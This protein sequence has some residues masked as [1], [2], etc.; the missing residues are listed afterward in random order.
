[1]PDAPQPR[2]PPLDGTVL[3]AHLT[4]GVRNVVLVVADGLGHHQLM[5]EIAAGNAPKLA[6]II[7]ASNAS[8][9]PL[10]SVFPTTTVAALGALNSAVTPAEHGLLSYTVFVPEFETIVEMIR[11]GPQNRRISFT[12]PEFGRSPEDF[13]WAETMYHRLH[14][15]GLERTFAVNPRGFAGTALTRMLHRGATYEGY[16]A[17]SSLSA[18]VAKALEDRPHTPTYVYAYWP[19]VDTISH[20]IGPRTEEHAAEVTAFDAA[21]ARLLRRIDGDATL[22]LL[23]ADHGHVDTGPEQQIA[24]DEHPELLGMLRQPPAGERRAIYLY[25]TDGRTQDVLSYVRANLRHV[26]T[27]LTQDE[28]IECGLF[29]PGP[30]SERA[31]GRIGDVILFP[32]GNLQ[33]VADIRG[34]DGTLMQQPQFKGLH[35]GLTEDEALVPLLAVRP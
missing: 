12:D 33:L 26:S 21:F 27:M 29:G 2:L 7:H 19:T 23:T 4:K 13:F 10:T 11:W 8:Y 35:G 30:I 16:I 9:E 31:R 1:V 20:V 18:L 15:A 34:P 14:A 6:E 25:V 32:R 22:V 3:P 17:T 24:L 28:A 5:R